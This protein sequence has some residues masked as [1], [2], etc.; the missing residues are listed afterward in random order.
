VAGI[1]WYHA[2]A[3]YRM[4]VVTGLFTRLHRTGRRI[5]PAWEN[6]GTGVPLLLGKAR[7]LLS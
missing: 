2:F 1:E 4:A 7:R 5:D 3:C 6:I